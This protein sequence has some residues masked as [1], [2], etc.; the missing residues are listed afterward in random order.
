MRVAA[1]RAREAAAAGAEGA[2][3]GGGAL[4]A[5]LHQKEM[6]DEQL[7]KCHADGSAR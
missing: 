7:V 1:Q 5:P 3:V 4:A 2:N 6:L